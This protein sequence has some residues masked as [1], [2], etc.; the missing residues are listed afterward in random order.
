[1]Y[2]PWF[3][4]LTFPTFPPGINGLSNKVLAVKVMSNPLNLELAQTRADTESVDRLVHLI[5]W[6]WSW[7]DIYHSFE[8]NMIWKYVNIEMSSMCKHWQ[9]YLRIIT[10]IMDNFRQCAL[11]GTEH[12]PPKPSGTSHWHQNVEA[13]GKT[14]FENVRA[15]VDLFWWNLSLGL[16]ILLTFTEFQTGISTEPVLSF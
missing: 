10:V 13:V 5:I 11:F 7:R 9:C 6:R 8:T 15:L 3:C 1:M 2:K 12:S 16:C 4:S 14:V